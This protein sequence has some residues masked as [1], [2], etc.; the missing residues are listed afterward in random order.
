MKK[1]SILFIAVA[2]MVVA[3]VIDIIDGYIPKLI[4]SASLTV[5]LLILAIGQDKPSKKVYNWLA[6]FF[7][8][9]T[10]SGFAYRLLHYYDIF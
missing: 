2:A 3:T 1:K 4:S 8:L 6:V 9:I 5:A 10:F 7:I